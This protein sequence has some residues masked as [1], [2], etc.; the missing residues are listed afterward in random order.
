MDAVGEK[1]LRAA[2]DAALDRCVKCHARRV[3]ADSLAQADDVKRDVDR[4]VS[5]AARAIIAAREAQGAPAPALGPDLVPDKA[6][7]LERAF[8]LAWKTSATTAWKGAYH[9]SPSHVFNDGLFPLGA[10]LADV[11]AAADAARRQAAPG[12]ATATS[13]PRKDVK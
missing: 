10:A 12:A 11:T 2:R 3:A 6:G 8:N 13:T 1:A 7:D 4:R 5:A 9:L